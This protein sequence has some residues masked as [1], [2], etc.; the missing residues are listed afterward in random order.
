MKLSNILLGC[1]IALL[2]FSLLQAVA[3]LTMVPVVFMAA[4]AFRIAE[5]LEG[6]SCIS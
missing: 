4:G 2:V 1:G 3:L 6:K 5:A